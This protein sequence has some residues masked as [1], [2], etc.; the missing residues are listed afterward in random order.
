M[1]RMDRHQVYTP[2]GFAFGAIILVLLQV[3]LTGC[4]QTPGFGFCHRFL[5]CTV[6]FASP[7]AYLYENQFIAVL[8][9]QVDLSPLAPVFP[10]DD[11]VSSF[12]QESPGGIL[13]PIPKHC[14]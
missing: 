12:F 2:V 4:H 3:I 9:Y 6:K 5:G 1:G 14:P 13:A 10:I 7:R 8:G 11:Q